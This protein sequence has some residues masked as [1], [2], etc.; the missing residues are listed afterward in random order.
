MDVVWRNGQLVFFGHAAF[1]GGITANLLWAA[2]SVFFLLLLLLAEK[3]QSKFWKMA[4]MYLYILHMPNASYLFLELKHLVLKDGI[5]DKLSALP[6]FVFG[7]LSITGL[8]LSIAQTYVVAT[9]ITPLNKYPQISILMLSA[10]SGWGAIL[11]L[12]EL[13]SPT[14]IFYPQVVIEY[15]MRAPIYLVMVGIAVSFVTTGGTLL[16]YRIINKRPG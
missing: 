8:V 15:T 11:G 16:T 3:K 6:V 2:S 7:T 1:P 5:A 12:M 14:G 4:F 13:L 10:L 9:K